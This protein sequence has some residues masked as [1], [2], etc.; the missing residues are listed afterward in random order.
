MNGEDAIDLLKFRCARFTDNSIEAYAL[1]EL[2]AAQDRLEH[3]ATL[4]PWFLI[5]DLYEVAMPTSG[6]TIALPPDY[7]M[8]VDAE[9]VYARD[10]TVSPTVR[11][12]LDRMKK[13]R[14]ES[15]YKE[16]GAR[17]QGYA[18]L[19]ETM[20]FRPAIENV[21][22]SDWQFEYRYYASES[23]IA[24]DDTTN[25][26]LTH[27]ADLVIAEAG[28]WIANN[29]LRNDSAARAFAASKQ[30]EKIRLLTF[31]TAREEQ[32]SEHYEED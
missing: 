29:Y 18:I 2:N 11:Y 17:P 19:G 12:G 8:A 5:S 31:I 28:L 27:A 24:N 15:N 26:W 9:A 23:D 32:D 16:Y 4:L 7:L 21:G 6:H 14:L 10:L 30:E 3:D 13:D 25:G 20:H 22:A 1:T